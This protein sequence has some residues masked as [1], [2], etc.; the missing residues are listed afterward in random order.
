MQKISAARGAWSICVGIL[1]AILGV[2]LMGFGIG[3]PAFRAACSL[4]CRN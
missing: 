1:L 2:G 4:K 3:Q